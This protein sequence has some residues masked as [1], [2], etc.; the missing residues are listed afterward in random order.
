M[1]IGQVQN[2]SSLNISKGLSTGQKLFVEVVSKEENGNGVISFAGKHIPAKLEVSALAGE[3]F[4][5]IVKEINMD[6][7][8]L[9]RIQN[10]SIKES[11][12]PVLAGRG[13]P[14]DEFLF[15]ILQDFAK[16]QLGL[17]ILADQN[18]SLNPLFPQW[19]TISATS[20]LSMLQNIVKLLGIDYE[21]RL[22]KLFSQQYS[23]IE[24][25][26]ELDVLRNSLKGE[27]LQSTENEKGLHSIIA[28]QLWLQ[29]GSKDHAY[30]LLG[31][32]FYDQ[33]SL[34][35]ARIAVES[36]RK[37]VKI[38]IA[39]CHFGIEL[40]TENL[41]TLGADVWL[42]EDQIHI[43]ILSDILKQDEELFQILIPEAKE[44]FEKIGL[45]LMTLQ[46]GPYEENKAFNQFIR[47]ERGKGVDLR[48]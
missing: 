44:R 43:R 45:K 13:L 33:E 29:T 15:T 23:E 39:H 47:G 37:G 19:E 9:A 18:S 42:Y 38:D 1:K 5:T 6:G 32:P 10:P 17:K 16:G 7:I 25:Q 11:N 34:R 8:T 46:Q 28:Q 35:E 36:V 22:Y 2:L 30:V 26:N 41:G 4:W 27:F 20:I 12:H 21:H 31:L 14:K 24:R 48:G 3:R 40:E